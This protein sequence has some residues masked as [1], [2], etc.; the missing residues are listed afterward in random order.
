MKVNARI[1]SPSFA[2]PA[3]SFGAALVRA[4]IESGFRSDRHGDHEFLFRLFLAV[5]E[6][7]VIPVHMGRPAMA[8][9][10]D[11]M[12][13]VLPALGTDAAGV[14]GVPDAIA[15]RAALPNVGGMRNPGTLRTEDLDLSHVEIS[16]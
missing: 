1:L 13:P 3:L 12:F 11:G 5:G 2:C 8:R 4:G 6:E 9:E 10:A 14:E 15:G 7:F 16:G